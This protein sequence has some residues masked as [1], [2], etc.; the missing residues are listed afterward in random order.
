MSVI[1]RAKARIRPVRQG[2]H[3]AGL[4]AATPALLTL[5]YPPLKLRDLDRATPT[6]RLY[7][8]ARIFV[9]RWCRCLF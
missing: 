6:H 9:G 3:L 2:I 4:P 1:E 8:H 5:N 7:Q